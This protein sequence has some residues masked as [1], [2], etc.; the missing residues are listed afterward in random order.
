MRFFPAKYTETEILYV[1][2]LGLCSVGSG[3]D[4][5]WSC[6]SSGEIVRYL[7]ISR[8]WRN[9]KSHCNWQN[10]NILYVKWN[11]VNDDLWNKSLN[12]KSLWL[13]RKHEKIKLWW[14]LFWL[15]FD[16]S[17]YET[18]PQVFPLKHMH[19]FSDSKHHRSNWIVSLAFKFKDW[20]IW[21]LKIFAGTDFLCDYQL[22]GT[23]QFLHHGQFHDITPWSL[24]LTAFYGSYGCRS[25]RVF[26]LFEKKWFA[27][28]WG[29]PTKAEEWWSGAVRFASQLFELQQHRW[30]SL[31]S[32]D[33]F[34]PTRLWSQE[35]SDFQGRCTSLNSFRGNFPEANLQGLQR[36]FFQ[37]TDIAKFQ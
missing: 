18:S 29:Q 6:E 14:F 25:Q 31:T 21:N 27:C 15:S 34:S 16:N 20:N 11:T 1:P 28:Y 17:L 24:A 3:S 4:G 8:G 13:W 26:F 5:D 22:F 36:P 12:L 7:E 23:D 9:L 37:S 33:T 10:W 19:L 2:S 32:C 35:S 30:R